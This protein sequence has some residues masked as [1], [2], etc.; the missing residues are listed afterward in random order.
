MKVVYTCWSV[1][2]CI[3]LAL[4]H[5]YC[6]HF[7]SASFPFHFICLQSSGYFRW[8][9]LLL[10]LLSS[11]VF[12]CRHIGL[13]PRFL[14]TTLLVNYSHHYYHQEHCQLYCTFAAAA[15]A[16]DDD[17]DHYHRWQLVMKQAAALPS[18]ACASS[19]SSSKYNF[20]SGG[21][22]KYHHR[23]SR[24]ANLKVLGWAFVWWWGWPDNYHCSA[25]HH[26]HQLTVHSFHSLSD[27][28][29]RAPGF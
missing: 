22:G 6:D 29:H 4:T 28:Y 27:T 19:S 13:I 26:H 11:A 14:F 16:Y 25:E 15:A 1:C 20:C 12:S 21:G 3:V 18:L 9:P 7:Y 17:D 10:L 24:V 8:S 5:F 2:C 23:R